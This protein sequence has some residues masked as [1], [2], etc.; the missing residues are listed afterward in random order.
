MVKQINTFGATVKTLLAKGYSQSWIAR[1]LKVKRQRVNYWALH[2]LKT[3]QTKK[4][5]FQMNKL[6]K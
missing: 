5:N 3:T 2:P 6:K 4:E 1:R